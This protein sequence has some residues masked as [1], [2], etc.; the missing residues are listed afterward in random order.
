[1]ITTAI[2]GASGYS[3]AELLRLLTFR[4][5]VRIVRVTAAA[6]VGKKVE[7]L[8]P[9]F[10]GTI[11]LPYEPSDP[12]RL[13][14]IDIVFVALPSGEAMNIVPHLLPRVER[15]IDLSGDFRLSSPSTYKEFYK[16]DHTAPHLLDEAVY[17][18]PE[19]NKDLITNA[20]L[21]ANPGCYPTSVILPLLPALKREI[22]SS[23]GIVINSLS[24]VSGA[25][26]TSAIDLSFTEV[27]ENIRAYKIGNHQ[28]IPEIQSVLEKATGESICFSF[29]PHLVPITRGIYSTIYADLKVPM[30]EKEILDVYREFYRDAP[31]V[32][33]RQHIPQIK[34]VVR[35][36]YCDIGLSIESRSNRLILVSV[37][38]N[39]GKGAAGQAIQ[40]M[41]IMFGHPEDR[42]LL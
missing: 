4:N 12:F 38:D 15:V 40:N 20:H 23:Q 32:R 29:V 26:R 25:G 19:L 30:T 13:E 7:D 5:D 39:L 1:M 17:G 33:I 3:G 8:Y 10:S 18:L 14:G 9:I 34:D 21:V 37:I 42:G 16:H 27:N 36:N 22:I 28:H 31:F 2:I 24:G 6:S 41:N 35:T 11:D